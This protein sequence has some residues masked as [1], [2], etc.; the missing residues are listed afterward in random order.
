VIDLL[1]SAGVPQL[2]WLADPTK[3]VVPSEE[4]RNQPH[5]ANER[6]VMFRVGF[7]CR[8]STLTAACAVV[9]YCSQLFAQSLTKNQNLNE[10]QIIGKD[11]FLDQTLS[12]RQN[13]SC[14]SCHAR[15]AGW[16]GPLSMTNA[17]GAVYEGSIPGRFGNR[18]PPSAAYA[19]P[20]PILS[21]DRKGTWSGG[22][23]WDGRATGEKLGNPSA[24][25]AQGPFLNPAEMALPDSACVVYRVCTGGYSSFFKKVIGADACA[26]SWPGNVESVCQTE[27][28]QVDL[29]PSD[30][31]T[32]NHTY[33]KIALAI[34]SFEDSPEVNAFTSKFDLSRKG[35][36]KLT[37]EERRGFALFQGKANCNNCHVTSGQQPL[38]T[39]YT[40]DNL[41]IPKN[42]ENP[43]YNQNPDF[44]DKGLGEFLKTIGQPPEIYEP[45]LGKEKVPTLRNVD[46]K[47][48]PGF[49]KAYGHNGYFKSLAEIVHFYNTRDVLPVCPQGSPGEGIYCWPPAEYPLNVNH[50][51]MGNLGLTPEEE[52]AIVAFLKTLSDGYLGR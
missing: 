8:L 41:G 1:I 32:S 20:S 44:I 38:F 40:Y 39:D 19:T 47:P 43:V 15:E 42:L 9:L 5:I 16:T 2:A 21:M 12:I 18:K 24:D 36:A 51:E 34:A 17:H 29:S 28:M 48:Y 6:T 10:V 33:D 46:K 37:G 30:R 52:A 27:G 50:D 35:R 14:A 13:Q 49:V 22:N 4:R 7:L 25:Q 31:A 26:I 3:R 23:F 45:N 11:I